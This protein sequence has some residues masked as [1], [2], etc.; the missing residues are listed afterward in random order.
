[1]IFNISSLSEIGRVLR[2]RKVARKR[3]SFSM[4]WIWNIFKG[5]NAFEHAE[6]KSEKFPLLW[7]AVF[8]QTF[9]LSPLISRK[10]L[11]TT[12]MD[13]DTRLHNSKWLII[14]WTSLYTFNKRPFCLDNCELPIWSTTL[15][16]KVPI[17]LSKIL[18]SGSHA[19]V[20]VKSQRR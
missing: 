14:L 1:M 15:H 13:E 6:F 9:I 2:S 3:F 20:N 5:N 10:F 12:R 19:D 8:S 7:R 4:S 16:E 18:S 17:S 11:S